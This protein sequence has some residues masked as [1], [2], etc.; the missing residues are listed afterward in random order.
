MSSTLSALL[1]ILAFGCAFPLAGQDVDA[2]AMQFRALMRSSPRLPMKM[3]EFHVQLPGSDQAIEFVSSLAIDSKGVI[4][5]FQRGLK[6]DPVI[7]VNQEG[8]TLRSWGRG[9]Y[10]IPHAI[11]IDA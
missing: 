2:R 9:L 11:R 4:Y 5:L 3:G 7:A 8:K 6:A 1:L 10:K